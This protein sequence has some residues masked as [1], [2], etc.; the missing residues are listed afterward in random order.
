MN[1]SDLTVCT[2]SLAPRTYSLIPL[3]YLVLNL[4][5]FIFAILSAKNGLS[6]I[7]HGAEKEY[8]LSYGVTVA[9]LILV[10]SV[11]VRILIA[12]QAPRIAGFLF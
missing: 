1:Y 6:V 9:L 8:G 7:T 3:K 4:P 2:S 10:Q 11:K 12:Q 5:A